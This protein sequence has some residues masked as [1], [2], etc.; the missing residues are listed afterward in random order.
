MVG[1]SRRFADGGYIFDRGRGGDFEVGG[2]QHR[3][4]FGHNRKNAFVEWLTGA[5]PAVGQALPP[6]GVAGERPRGGDGVVRESEGVAV[7]GGL[8]N[9]RLGGVICNRSAATDQVDKFNERVGLKMMARFPDLDA[10]RRS[11]LKKQTLFEMEATPEMEAVQQEYM[12][13]AQALWDG[14]EGLAVAPL[15][16]REIFD[17]LGFD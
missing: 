6:Q 12:R 7:A 15:K 16:D 5:G 4:F 14:T 1:G 8:H 9:V 11:R 13:L 17:L 10:I 2:S 3:A